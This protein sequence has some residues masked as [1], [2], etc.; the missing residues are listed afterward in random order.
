MT[1]TPINKKSPPRIA[2]GGLV[3]VHHYADADRRAEMSQRDVHL[4]ARLLQA[5]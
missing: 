5:R 1:F 4:F 2:G 3:H